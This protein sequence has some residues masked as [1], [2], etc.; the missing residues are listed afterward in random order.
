MRKGGILNPNISKAI[1]ALGHT[2]YLVIADPGLPIPENVHV[3]DISF[4]KGIPSFI[5]VLTA[6]KEEL[7]I[8]S[9]IFAMEMEDVNRSLFDGMD[10]LLN[11][12]PSQKVPHEDLKKL[13]Q[14][15]SVVIRTGE[16]SSYANLI[17]VGG[18][19]F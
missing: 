6:V 4:K 11:E 7:V 10:A 19:N 2:Q 17:L 16:C 15:A 12:V 18:V 8:E 1:A 5:E 14:N 13:I 9:Y 3:I